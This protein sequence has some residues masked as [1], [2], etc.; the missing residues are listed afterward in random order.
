VKRNRWILAV[1]AVAVVALGG[2]WW[3]GRNAAAAP[4]YRTTEVERGTIEAVVSA[5]GT[6]RPVVQVEVGSQVSG[7]VVRIFS[8]YNARVRQ[9]Q[10]LLQLDPASFR[11]RVIQNQAA[12][13]KAE[14]ALKDAERSLR[15]AQELVKQNYISQAEVE[16]ADV[17][18]EQRRAELRQA[19]AQLQVAQVDLANTT[20]RAPI[21]GVVIARSIDLGQTVAA[22]LQAPKLFVIANDLSR[23][24]VETKIDEADIGRI[25]PGLPVTFTVDAFPDMTFEGRVAQVRLE[26][27]VEQNVVTYTTVIHTDNPALKLRPGMTANVTVRTAKRDDVLKVPAAALR[28]RPPAD[29]KARDERGGAFAASSPGGSG[30]G[31]GIGQGRGS[32][33]ARAGASARDPGG[34]RAADRATAPQAGGSAESGTGARGDRSGGERRAMRDAGGD[35]SA[36][37]AA[38]GMVA[39][40]GGENAPADETPA[41]KPGAVFV[42]RDDKPVRVPVLTGLSDGAS[43]EVQS[44][45]LDQGDA[46][47]VGLEQPVAR[48]PQMQPPPG[49]GGPQFRG[50]GGRRG[51]GGGR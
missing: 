2:W 48:G 7:T 40:E 31:G 20:I 1:L 24:Q 37:S 5:T 9:G 16:G 13:A 34:K 43:V 47:I 18:V 49:M 12:V 3:K 35:P 4:K 44:R 45:E 25:H 11:A 32:Q 41:M 23:M 46:V 8:D 27:I 38:Q 10:V 51:G 26:P 22:S 39:G 50:P 17:T 21:D 14:A 15:R 29:P 19:R 42:L 33:T 36:A 30:S 6:V 28:F